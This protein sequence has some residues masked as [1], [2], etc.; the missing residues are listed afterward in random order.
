MIA[1]PAVASEVTVKL[2]LPASAVLPAVALA[3]PGLDEVTV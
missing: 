2:T 3:M 1:W